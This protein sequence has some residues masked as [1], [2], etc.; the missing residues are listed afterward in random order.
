M[1][2]RA[3][4]TL[5]ELLVVIAIIAILAAILFP[6]FAKA[7]EKARQTQ[8]LSNV[9]QI[10][11]AALMYAE[12]WEGCICPG[13]RSGPDPNRW[14]EILDPYM[15]NQ[16]ILRCPSTSLSRGYGISATVGRWNNTRKLAEIPR[17][18]G[19]VF[20]MDAAQCD[21]NVVGDT[22]PKTWQNY[23]TG[24][25]DWQ[26]EMPSTWTGSTGRYNSDDQW[27]NRRRRPIARHNEGLNIS[28]IDGHAKWM[29]IESF[30]GIPQNGIDGW[31]YGDPRNLWDN[32]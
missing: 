32:K 23:V 12:D 26:V 24:P 6:V 9:R 10:A 8:C 11:T 13:G 30:L 28:F 18:A 29:E 20:F 14:H 27:G 3:A 21:Q 16:D 19:T 4:F 2:K 5:I 15:K 17:P 1:S 7:R 31:P 25:T 22:N